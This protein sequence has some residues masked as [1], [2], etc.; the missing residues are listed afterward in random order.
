MCLF[1]EMIL[2]MKVVKGRGCF[3]VLPRK[4]GRFGLDPCLAVLSS[5][6]VACKSVKGY[7]ALRGDC[8]LEFPRLIIE[9]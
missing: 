2:K 7:M 1:F 3:V 5:K 6:E 8:K 4:D 9:F